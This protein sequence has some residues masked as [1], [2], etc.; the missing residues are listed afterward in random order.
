M[1]K[2][3]GGQ[4]G[5]HV[6][7]MSFL[8]SEFSLAFNPLP[9][10]IRVDTYLWHMT[11]S[12]IAWGGVIASRQALSCQ[13]RDGESE[14][15]RNRRV[16][17]SNAPVTAILYLSEIGRLRASAAGGKG[18]LGGREIGMCAAHVSLASRWVGWHRVNHRLPRGI[19]LFTSP[20]ARCCYY[21]VSGGRADM[22][23]GRL[24][25]QIPPAGQR[26]NQGF[27]H[28]ARVTWAGKHPVSFRMRFIVH[29]CFK[30]SSAQRH[31]RGHELYS[32]GQSHTKG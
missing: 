14:R 9:T 3:G 5:V 1:E 20:F 8:I 27:V 21:S 19:H 28:D 24:S 18:E 16:C 30:P 6:T 13:W 17:G 10:V 4:W 2:E 11:V 29:W 22:F 7:A 26:S 23:S 12:L 15:W 32:D 31:M 25:E